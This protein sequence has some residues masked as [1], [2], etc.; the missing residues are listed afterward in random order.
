MKLKKLAG[1]ASFTTREAQE[2]GLSPRMLSYY[3][4]TGQLLRIARGV[5]CSSKYET[6]ME[7]LKWEDMAIAASN[8]KGGVICLISA[9]NFYELTDE[10]MKEFWIAVDNN[11]SKAKFP[12]CH[13]VRMRNMDI[14]VMEIELANIKVK[15]F[16]VERTIIDSFR[17]LDFET[18]MKALKIY[19]N[20]K[21]NIKKL[22]KYATLLRA[23]KVREYIMALIA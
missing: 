1:K 12:M 13:I 22:S 21:P 6:K 10:I 7:N 16:D 23:S 2:F 11:N 20:G 5:Y 19:L 17:L 14:G 15:I 4:K 9:L 3:V 8:I 18:A